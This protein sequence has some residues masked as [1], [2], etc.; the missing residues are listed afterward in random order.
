MILKDLDCRKSVAQNNDYESWGL[1]LVNY[2]FMHTQVINQYLSFF[3]Y[4]NS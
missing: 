4:T 1:T 3:V 2:P